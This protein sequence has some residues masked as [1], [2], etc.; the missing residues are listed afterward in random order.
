LGGAYSNTQKLPVSAGD[1]CGGTNLNRSEKDKEKKRDKSEIEAD[2]FYRDGGSRTNSCSRI[3][4]KGW[5][6]R[7]RGKADPPYKRVGGSPYRSGRKTEE[8]RGAAK[9]LREKT[10]GGEGSIR[11]RR[12][13]D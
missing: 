8:V 10:I 1:N 3:G 12:R 13:D 5:G 7:V 2:V 4:K 9:E 6:R 11:R